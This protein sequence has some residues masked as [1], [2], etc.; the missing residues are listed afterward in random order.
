[1]STLTLPFHTRGRDGRILIK[2]RPNDD[3]YA[4]GHDRVAK[5]SPTIETSTGA[6][7]LS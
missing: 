4:T 3:P 5:S 6:P 2:V 7:T 1:M